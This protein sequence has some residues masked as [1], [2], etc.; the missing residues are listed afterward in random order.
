M[1]V[2]PR[3]AVVLT[4]LSALLVGL[5]PALGA[6]RANVAEALAEAARESGLAC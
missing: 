5:L 3:V 1:R 6:S 4:L 2:E